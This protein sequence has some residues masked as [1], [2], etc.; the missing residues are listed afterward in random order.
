VESSLTQLL[1]RQDNVITR[2]QALK[3]LSDKTVRHRVEAGRWRRLHL[4]VFIANTGVITANQRNWLAVLSAGADRHPDVCLAGLTALRQWGLHSID[5]NAVHVLIAQP[6]QARVPAGTQVHRSRVRPEVISPNS[7]RPPMTF[8][9]RSLLDAAQWARSDRQARLFVAASFQRE[10]VTLADV[11]RAAE[12]QPN[13][14]RRRLVLATA[15][16][17]AGGSHSLPEL[18]LLALC[19]RFRLP[20]PTRQAT[21]RD[22]SGRL[23]FLDAAFDEWRVAVEVDGA[24]HLEVA[25]MWDD[26][27]KSNALELDGYVV[28]RYP[29]FALRSEAARIAAEIREA[30]RRAG[31][32]DSSPAQGPRIAPSYR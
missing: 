28:L 12:E 13:A 21:R 4:G 26:A 1:A 11:R 27:V 6:R 10:L 15:E 23:R 19:R 31:W 8:P 5:S 16:D 18:D 22:R 7:I 3:F 14:Q 32:G 17:C 29:A 2:H 20:T 25:R 30:L 24:H 9:G